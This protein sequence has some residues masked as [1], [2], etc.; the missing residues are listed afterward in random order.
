MTV[1]FATIGVNGSSS[2]CAAMIG[3]AMRPSDVP[4]K[5]MNRMGYG[6]EGFLASP[7]VVA[8]SAMLGYMGGPEELG[9]A[10]D[11]ATFAI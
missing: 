5:A 2:I 3:P 1:D 6:G 7:S 10:W 11:A 4:T 8:A 9:I